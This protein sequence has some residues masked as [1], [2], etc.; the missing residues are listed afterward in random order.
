MMASSVSSRNMNFK[1]P[2]RENTVVDGVAGR[3]EVQWID[4][5]P[6]SFAYRVD[7]SNDIT[8]NHPFHFPFQVDA[9]KTT[10]KVEKQNRDNF[11]SM[12][13]DSKISRNFF[14]IG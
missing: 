4:L 12:I 2:K 6:Q 5:F 3:N 13:R 8:T 10:G 11:L 7:D 9:A 1:Y 14:L